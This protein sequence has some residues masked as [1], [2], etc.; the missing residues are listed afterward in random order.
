MIVSYK[1][2]VFYFVLILVVGAAYELGLVGARL[3]VAL[4]L[5]AQNNLSRSI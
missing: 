3:L 1:M 2:H 4:A 5:N